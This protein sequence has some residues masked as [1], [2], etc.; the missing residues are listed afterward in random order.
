MPSR[1]FSQRL[2]AFNAVLYL[3]AGVQLPFLPLWL[4]DRGFN[5]GQIAQL[6]AISTAIRVLAIP[7]GTFVADRLGK[8]RGIII[9]C[10]FA[11]FACYVLTGLASSFGSIVFLVAAAVAFYAPI[12]PLIEVMSMEG[13]NL[14][15]LDYGRIRLWASLSFLAG[16]LIAGGLLEAIPVSSVVFLIAAG[17]G[18]MALCALALPADSSHGNAAHEPVQVGRLARLILQPKV[19]MFFA[20]A[21][22]GQATHG[23]F[24][25]FGSVHWEKQGFGKLTIGELWVI[26]ILCEVAMFAYSNR[27]FAAFG[28]RRLIAIGIGCG[29]IRWLMIGMEP[30]LALLFA[31]QVLHVGSF[32]MTHLGTMHYIQEVVP[33]GMRNSVQGAYSALTGGVLMAVS[34]WSAGPLYAAFGGGAYFVMAGFS[35][36]ALVLAI[37]LMRISPTGPK[38]ADA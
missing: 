20:A 37:L 12:A 8:R 11:S 16:S 23:L 6:L 34:M 29:L 19:L 35:A 17:Q 14:H 18:L 38:A 15:G 21:G 5:V 2:S 32:A 24:Y 27:V 7:L 4:S 31:A 9:A 22:I 10:A 25:A 13:S 36:L 30:P 26:G 33:V 3:G 1:I 28:A